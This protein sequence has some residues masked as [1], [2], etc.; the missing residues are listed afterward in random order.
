MVTRKINTICKLKQFIFQVVVISSIASVKPVSVKALNSSKKYL[1][2]F[3]IKW[4]LVLSEIQQQSTLAD[5][6]R[7]LEVWIES[8]VLIVDT[9]ASSIP[10]DCIYR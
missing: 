3:Q 6:K 7:N 4:N 2:L 10:L 1:T 9:M 5:I 8:N